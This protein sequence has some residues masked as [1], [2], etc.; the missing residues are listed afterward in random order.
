MKAITFPLLL[1]ATLIQP[2]LAAPASHIP[3]VH[4]R[5]LGGASN[6]TN[7]TNGIDSVAEYRANQVKNTFLT[8]WNG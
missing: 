3:S 8:A 5:S 4:D 7:G 6:N 1:A 2:L